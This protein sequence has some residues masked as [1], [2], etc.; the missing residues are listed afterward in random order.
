MVIESLRPSWKSYY[1][2]VAD[3]L[4]KGGELAVKPEEARRVVAVLDA[5][6]ESL[7]TRARVAVASTWG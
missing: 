5:A 3:V 6:A 2:N 4:L 1:Q 7:S